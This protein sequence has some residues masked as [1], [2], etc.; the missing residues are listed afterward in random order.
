[1]TASLSS[2]PK[3]SGGFE[4]WSWFFM[5]I[6][7]LLLLGLALGHLVIM[8]LIHNVDEIDYA[9]VAGRYVSG[10]WRGYDLMMLVLAMFHGVNGMRILI[11]DYVHPPMWRRVALGALSVIGGGFLLLGIY[12]IVCFQPVT[13]G[14]RL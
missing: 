6:S 14:S 10:F 2:S 11:D 1:M 12:V 9:F 13:G 5:R 8:H 4:L 3:P 7:G